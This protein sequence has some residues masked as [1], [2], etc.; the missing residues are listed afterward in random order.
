ML[1][2]GEV[3]SYIKTE[4]VKVFCYDE[5]DSTSTLARQLVNGGE[6]NLLIITSD[7]Q[8]GGRGRNGKSFYSLN[9]GSVYMSVVLHP[10]LEFADAVGIT[11]AAAVAVSRAIE[12]VTGRVTDIKWVNDLYY[13]EKKVCGILCEAVASKGI[14]SSVIIGVGIN[15][16]ECSFPDELKNIAG[17]LGCDSS[18]RAQLIAAVADE[19]F[20][21]DF[22][23]LSD[24]I[25]D[26]YR[27]KSIVIGKKIDYYIKGK[28]NTASA[29]GIDANGGLIIE[30]SDGSTDVLR[31][32][33]ISL[34]LSE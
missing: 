6:K 20:S 5:I 27:R 13:C 24:E 21:L 34:R 30:I 31:S 17:T 8:T 22:G 18:L 19:L 29:V 33:E 1:N 16:P 3:L 15:L 23:K 9:D 26:E 14:V 25:L 10:N 12:S 2:K 11:T 28:K 4:N 7:K 32:G